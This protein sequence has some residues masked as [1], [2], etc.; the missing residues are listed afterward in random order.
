MLQYYYPRTIRSIVVGLLNAFND[1]KVFSYTNVV[2]GTTSAASNEIDVDIFFA[3]SDK[4]YISRKEEASG[5]R[6]YNSYPKIS[7]QLTGLSFEPDRAKGAR[8]FRDFHDNTRS[9]NALSTFFE[10]VHPVP[11]RYDFDVEIRTQLFDHMSQILENILPYFNPYIV[12]RLKEFSFLNL[13]SEAQAE[14]VGDVQIQTNEPL[15]ETSKREVKAS[16]GVQVHGWMYRPISYASI[17]KTIHTTYFINSHDVSGVISEYNIS[18]SRY[19]TSGVDGYVTS[20]FPNRFLTSS[21]DPVTD[22]YLFT[23]GANFR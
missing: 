15:E 16:F 9:F 11:Y 8:D 10:D 1:L 13:K 23:S 6:Y 5:K 2:S 4:A 17:I 12:L 20:A 14:M 22:V 19:I 7:I 3:Q 18:A 21:F